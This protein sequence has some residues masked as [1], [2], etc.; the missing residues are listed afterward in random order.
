MHIAQQITSQPSSLDENETITLDYETRFLRRKKLVS[1][2]GEAFLVELPDTRSVNEGEGFVLDDGRVIFVRAA[3]EPLLSVTHD[4]L[5]R[6]AW[7]IGNRHTPCQ[8]YDDKLL[9]R[10]D[11][12]LK[13]M[14]E[15]L[16]AE[17]EVIHAPFLPEGGAYG[18]GRTH[19]HVHSHK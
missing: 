11:D 10:Q 16:G 19:S 6:I 13:K 3:S 12:V 2:A 4:H 14:L 5:P 15:H 8:F 9:L 1:D 18:L 7:H 17:I